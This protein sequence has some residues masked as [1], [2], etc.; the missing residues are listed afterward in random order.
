MDP[1]L[2]FLSPYEL[3]TT[4]GNVTRA[5]SLINS[6]IPPEQ[7]TK[8]MN[9]LKDITR[10]IAAKRREYQVKEA[11]KM[12][13]DKQERVRDLYGQ[14]GLN[15]TTWKAEPN[16]QSRYGLRNRTQPGDPMQGSLQTR[17]YY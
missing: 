4:D 5:W 9:Y 14:G 12:H 10:Q 1:S 7:K 15:N 11:K 2:S 13:S 16:Q 3:A 8:Y 6:N 17:A